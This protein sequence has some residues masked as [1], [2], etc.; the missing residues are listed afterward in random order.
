MITAIS[1]KGHKENVALGCNR[2]AFVFEEGLRGKLVGVLVH[3]KSLDSYVR[4]CRFCFIVCH[5]NNK[6]T[7]GVN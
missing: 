3:L 2:G 6:L 7:N 1:P 4:Y 5:M